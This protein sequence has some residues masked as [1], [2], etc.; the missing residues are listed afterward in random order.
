MEEMLETY[1][2]VVKKIQTIF[3]FKSLTLREE[4]RAE[5]FGGGIIFKYFLRIKHMRMFTESS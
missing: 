4:L 3:Q 1:V 5:G 2:Q